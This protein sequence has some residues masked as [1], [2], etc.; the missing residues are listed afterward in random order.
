MFHRTLSINTCMSGGGRGGVI[1][2]C[3]TNRPHWGY[4]TPG[5]GWVC[6]HVGILR[7]PSPG[8]GWH[9]SKNN[10]YISHIGILYFPL[11]LSLMPSPIPTILLAG[12]QR[13]KNEN[14]E[15]IWKLLVNLHF[16]ENF[17][18]GLNNAS[19]A[20][21]TCSA[22]SSQFLL[23]HFQYTIFGIWISICTFSNFCI[24]STQ[25]IW[26]RATKI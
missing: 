1:K 6:A 10:S 25:Y 21:L 15:I 11:S 5:S 9:Y 4:L 26:C 23:F 16:L 13:M 12:T 17:R 14:I 20:S 19:C 18:L 7:L 24:S 8:I 2:G 22:F 3:R